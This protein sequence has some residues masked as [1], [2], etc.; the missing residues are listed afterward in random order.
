MAR[1]GHR[2]S[3]DTATHSTITRQTSFNV[4]Q[5]TTNTQSSS[6]QSKQNNKHSKHNKTSGNNLLLQ[7]SHD[8]DSQPASQQSTTNRNPFRNKNKVPT[9]RKGASLSSKSSLKS[10][11]EGNIVITTTASRG[12]VSSTTSRSVAEE[13]GRREASSC[14]RGS[15]VSQAKKS[16][17]NTTNNDELCGIENSS[18]PKN[19]WMEAHKETT[20]ESDMVLVASITTRVL[21]PKMKFFTDLQISYSDSQKRVAQFIIGKCNLK[22]VMDEK[23]WWD[24]MSTTV[25]RTIVNLR[26]SKTTTMRWS[27][28]GKYCCSP[29]W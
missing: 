7:H 4:N 27:F 29:H 1:K 2:K 6:Q 13:N 8:D 18:V 5:N 12:E 14:S 15:M 24:G 28:F 9:K 16:R 26:N 25:S 3:R 10:T 23:E 22:N 11:L 21:W 19:L 17:I 20:H